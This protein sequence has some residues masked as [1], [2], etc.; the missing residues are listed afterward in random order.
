MLYERADTPGLP[1]VAYHHANLRKMHGARQS[2]MPIESHL[3]KGVERIL[4]PTE[5]R[6]SAGAGVYPQLTCRS[7]I[8][9]FG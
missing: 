1:I 9:R 2:V 5:G 8:Y 6:F 4:P 7:W 3:A